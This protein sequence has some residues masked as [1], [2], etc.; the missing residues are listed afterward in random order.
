MNPRNPPAP[1]L[2]TIVVAVVAALAMAAAGVADEI[3]DRLRP[4]VGEVLDV[5][6]LGSG[7]RLVRPLLER[8]VEAEGRVTAL[9]LRPEGEK[10]VTSLALAGVVKIVADRET[11]YETAPKGATRQREQR[12][13][14]MKNAA[15]I[16]RMRARGVEPWPE[17]SAEEHE[18][19][20]ER[21]ERFVAEVQKLFP[22]LRV[23]RTHEFLVATDIPPNQM[24][25]YVAKLDTMHDTLCDLYG[26]PRGE[27]V[28]KGKCLVIAFLAEADYVAFEAR[29]MRVETRGTHGLCHQG[30]DGRVIMAC[31]RG[32]D[33]AAFA[34]MLVHETSHGFNH[35]WLSP[36]RLPNWLNEGIA[37]WVAAKVVPTSNQVQLKEAVAAD[38]MRANGNLGPEFFERPNIAPVQY[39]MASSM[40]RMLAGRDARKF[41][42]FVAAVKEGTPPEEAL[43]DAF[44]YD[45]DGLVQAY[46][47]LVGVPALRR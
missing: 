41:G 18:A 29:V 15:A 28:W 31:H 25:P 12:Q 38:F 30:S 2:R 13:R 45:V 40:V 26:I 7:K 43:R 36:T 3:A 6:E 35:R 11:V 14:E 44:K 32:D 39:G 47:K 37:E 27:P 5:V 42:G 20:V 10:K 46:G 16:E 21:L 22:R 19:E 9:R 4:H 34:H 23:S 33:E 1:R 24:A 17:L 8:L